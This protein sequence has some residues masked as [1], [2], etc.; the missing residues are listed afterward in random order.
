MRYPQEDD[1]PW[2]RQF[3]PWF[4]LTPPLFGV[5]LGLA[6][7]SAALHEPD[8]LVVDDYYQHGRTINKILEREQFAQM[9]GL[10]AALSWD[11]HDVQL[12]LYASAPL[13]A[14][15]LKLSFLHPTRAQQDVI[16]WLEY[17]PVQQIY[18]ARAD[19]PLPP[20]TWHVRLEP[21][22]MT[23]RLRARL[24]HSTQQQLTLLSQD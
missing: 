11:E 14:Q 10:S 24:P 13:P 7:V 6:L 16:L 4:V 2:Y 3:W 8:G 21:H 22:D 23:W 20:L 19:A 18:H 1:K 17:D 15:P 9:L 5:L 12:Q